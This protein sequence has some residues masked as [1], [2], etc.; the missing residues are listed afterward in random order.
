MN[1]NWKDTVYILNKVHNEQ[2]TNINQTYKFYDV[3]KLDQDLVEPIENEKYYD[4]NITDNT[5]QKKRRNRK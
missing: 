1:Y 2:K 5:R 3:D 4:E